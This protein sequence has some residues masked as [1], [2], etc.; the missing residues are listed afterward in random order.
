MDLNRLGKGVY[1]NAV[2]R[3]FE[4]DDINA[5]PTLAPEIMP[6]HDLWSR[7][8]FWALHGGNLVGGR[9]ALAANGAGTNGQVAIFNPLTSGAIGLLEQIILGTA[10]LYTWGLIVGGGALAGVSKQ[11]RDV[12]RQRTD[13]SAGMQLEFLAGNG[14]PITNAIFGALTGPEVVPIDVVIPPGFGV[15]VTGPVNTAADITLNW[16]ERSASRL[17]LLLG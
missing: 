5:V 7:P 17:E 15:C 14:A 3:V 6:V 10:Q 4:L 12:R 9:A 11:S 13:S 16:R 2:A 8:E 1:G